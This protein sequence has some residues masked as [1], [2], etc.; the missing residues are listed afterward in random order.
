[1]FELTGFKLE[2]TVA[3]ENAAPGFRESRP[4][5]PLHRPT[6]ICCSKN[7]RVAAGAGTLTMEALE[8]L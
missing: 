6:S 1:V 7:K 5:D 8:W 4:D 3:E 2:F